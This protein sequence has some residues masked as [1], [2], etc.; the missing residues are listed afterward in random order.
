[1]LVMSVP[2]AGA[3]MKPAQELSTGSGFGRP[4]AE[5]VEA[6]VDGEME[7]DHLVPDYLAGRWPAAGEVAHHFRIAVQVNQ[8]AYIGLGEPAQDLSRCFQDAPPRGAAARHPPMAAT[9]V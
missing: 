5:P 9:A 2:G 8:V 6:V 4:G 7:R 3:E 1:M